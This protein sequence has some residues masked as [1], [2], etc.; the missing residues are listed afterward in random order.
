MSNVIEFPKPHQLEHEPDDH[1]GGCPECG[2]YDD[3]LNIGRDHWFLCSKHKTKWCFGSNIFSSWRD[4]DERVWRANWQRLEEYRE[5]RPVY[6][7]RSHATDPN[8]ATRP[9]SHD[10]ELPFPW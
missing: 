6:P 1:F 5:V 7:A 9:A 3:V 8:T 4:E 2:G 10:E